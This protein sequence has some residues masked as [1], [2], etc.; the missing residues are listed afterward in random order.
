M[1][2]DGPTDPSSGPPRLV[3][4]ETMTNGHGGPSPIQGETSVADLLTLIGEDPSR[5][6]LRDTP[7]RVVQALQELTSG[8]QQDPETILAR[9]F[10]DTHDEMVVVHGVEFWS[11][12]EH[13]LLPFHGT[14]SV[15]YLPNGRIVGLSKLARLV[16]AYAR[17][18][19][20][21]ERL[22]DQ[23]ADAIDQ[24]LD[25]RGAAVHIEATHTCMAMR[26]VRSPATTVTRAFRGVLREAEP[27]REFLQLVQQRTSEP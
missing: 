27:R 16:N 5:E 25:A 11:L 23:I 17:R 7:R 3:V 9:D 14:A 1:C 2:A 12:C 13:H 15:G 26:G 21:Q 18:L 24:H 6:G 19:Q 20:V 22:T 4:P 8:Y 10:Q